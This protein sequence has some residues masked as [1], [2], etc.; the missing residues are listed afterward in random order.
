M[1][2]AQQQRPFP[3]GFHPAVSAWFAHAFDAPTDVQLA[4][5]K[6]IVAGPR[7]LIAAPT[8]S[9]KT[10][11]AFMCAINDLVVQSRTLP[12]DDKVRVLYV[13]PLK[14]LSNDIEKNL[15]APR[16]APVTRRP[17]SA[18]R[19]PGAHRRSW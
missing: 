8:G 16:C 15:Q 17:A 4:A 2:E 12:L 7:V 14:A 9:G 5:W 11:A 18:P 13:S 10:L 1:P 3:E 19:W 6:E